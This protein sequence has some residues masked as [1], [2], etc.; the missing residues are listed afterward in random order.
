M[1]T[2]E[3]RLGPTMWWHADLPAA[4]AS[5]PASGTSP[6]SADQGESLL[7]WILPDLGEDARS[8]RLWR[9]SSDGSKRRALR[10]E[11]RDDG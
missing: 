4:L 1:S 2:S 7:E 3:P 9:D 10:R 5:A 8:R 11:L 6:E